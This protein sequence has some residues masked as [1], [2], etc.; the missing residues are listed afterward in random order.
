[1]NIKQLLL[2]PVVLILGACSTTHTPTT[3]Q[4]SNYEFNGLKTYALIGDK[5]LRNPLVS[6]IDRERIDNAINNALTAQG[7]NAVDQET[8]DITVSYYIVTK[9]KV[10]SYSHYGATRSACYSCG[11]RTTV[12]Q[13]NTRSYVEGTLVLDVF[14]NKAEKSVWRSSLTKTLKK[15]NSPEE[16]DQAINEV[17]SAMLAELPLVQV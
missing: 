11:P 7:I 2:L 10:R 5:N 6:D 1:M 12:I 17:V 4:V 8:A 13:T 3:D 15:A 9:D 16:R 14:D